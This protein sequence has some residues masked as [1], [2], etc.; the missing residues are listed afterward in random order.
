MSCFT[1]RNRLGKKDPDVCPITGAGNFQRCRDVKLPAGLHEGLGILLP[2][3]FVKVSREEIAAVIGKQRK[4]ADGLFARQMV[5]DQLI[6]Y[7]Q[8]LAL[9]AVSTFHS[10]FMADA[11]LPLIA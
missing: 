4:D 1:G 2:V 8:Q 11:G 5:V 10:W 7:R 3:S 6:G 9:A